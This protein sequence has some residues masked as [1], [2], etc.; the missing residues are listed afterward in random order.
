RGLKLL[1]GTQTILGRVR[2]SSDSNDLGPQAAVLVTL[3]A[4]MLDA[5]AQQAAPLLG[6]DTAVVFVQN[7]LPWW[8]EGAPAA[9][10]PNGLL[11][12]NIPMD[13]VAGG[14]AYSANEVIEPGVGENHVPGNNMVV[15]GR[16]D[17]V[18][19]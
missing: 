11:H 14:V 3:K 17:K 5:F 2:A 12:R 18:D 13:R 6:P 4:N 7:G 1:H 16:P 15:V 10:D 9:L 8:Y 19:S